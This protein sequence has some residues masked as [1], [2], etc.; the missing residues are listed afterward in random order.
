VRPLEVRRGGSLDLHPH[1]EPVRLPEGD[2]VVGTIKVGAGIR[3]ADLFLGH[4]IRLAQERVDLER[5]R[6]AHAVQGERPFRLRGL[7]AVPLGEFAHTGG[8]EY[9]AAAPSDWMASRA[10]ACSRPAAG[11][12]STARAA[13]SAFRRGC[14]TRT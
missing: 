10:A 1:L 14:S 12:R 8:V 13:A 2:A 9:F 7:V 5:E 6:L 11:E 3:T 4:W